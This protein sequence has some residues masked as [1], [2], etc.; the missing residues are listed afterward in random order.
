MSTLSLLTKINSFINK[1][2]KILI[3]RLIFPSNW[4]RICPYETPEG[5]ACGLIK[6]FSIIVNLSITSLD[7]AIIYILIIVGLKKNFLH[8]FS[9]NI[10]KK[11]SFIFI[12]KNLVGFHKNFLY[13]YYILKFHCYN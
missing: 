11:I 13:F 10:L 7:K 12:N 5:E 4:C 6:N 8:V 9:K 2:R 1:K 3:P